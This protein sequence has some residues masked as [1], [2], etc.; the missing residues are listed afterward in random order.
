[1]SELHNDRRGR[2]LA[3]KQF[4][5]AVPFTFCLE[6]HNYR[7]NYFVFV[8]DALYFHDLEAVVQQ[9]EIFGRIASRR[10]FD[11][12]IDETAFLCKKL[13]V[14]VPGHQ[15]SA[16]IRSLTD[17]VNNLAIST[18][19]GEVIHID[20]QGNMQVW[21][22]RGQFDLPCYE[23]NC[24]SPYFQMLLLGQRMKFV[25]MDGNK[26]SIRR[27][28]NIHCAKLNSKIRKG[29]PLEGTIVSKELENLVL[30]LGYEIQASLQIVKCSQK[31]IS[32]QFQVGDVVLI[33]SVQP[34]DAFNMNQVEAYHFFSHHLEIQMMVGLIIRF[35]RKGSKSFITVALGINELIEVECET[36]AHI[37]YGPG[38]YVILKR[39]EEGKY[40]LYKP[41]W[42]RYVS[43][44]YGPKAEVNTIFEGQY[45]YYISF[46]NSETVP[47]D[48]VNEIQPACAYSLVPGNLF[49]CV[50]KSLGPVDSV[51]LP[52]LIGQPVNVGIDFCRT[53]GLTSPWVEYIPMEDSR[54]D[55]D[56]IL[57]MHPAPGTTIHPSHQV[58]YAVPKKEI[59]PFQIFR[60]E[61]VRLSSSTRSISQYL[62]IDSV[63]DDDWKILVLKFFA[64]HAYATRFQL[65]YYLKLHQLEKEQP[66]ERL[67]SRCL[68][69]NILIR[70]DI[71]NE[72]RCSVRA[73]SL[74]PLVAK[75]CHKKVG[76]RILPHSFLYYFGDSATIKTVLSANQAYLYLHTQYRGVSSVR[77]YS[78]FIQNIRPAT[79]EKGLVKIYLC[80]VLQRRAVLFF[81]SIR[82]YT[83][84]RYLNKK[85]LPY[86]EE[87]INK[88][89]RLETFVAERSP[90]DPYEVI[91]Y[92]LCETRNH[93]EL[94]RDALSQDSRIQGIRHIQ[95][96]YITD[97]D[98]NLNRFDPKTS[99]FP[100]IDMDK[101][102]TENAI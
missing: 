88:I 56:C 90:W 102:E 46:A 19:E 12:L 64:Y 43:F 79:V 15:E 94:L 82:D 18:V 16:Y 55:E 98:T 97:I 89:L 99:P 41:F 37:F 45:Q 2:F 28:R 100:Q 74:N 87:Y 3:L 7:H 69:L 57:E 42:K 53:H 101:E 68:A 13:N 95:L 21:T 35:V 61:Q 4:Y 9:N 83:K 22:N 70:Y 93:Q 65:L 1:M 20:T 24:Q 32:K 72:H 17:Y 23:H 77:Y 27:Y 51:I 48:E 26:V 85:R 86:P 62:D 29:E 76:D 33:Q 39:E 49:Y 91:L 58:L 96:R 63:F 8:N 75:K 80:C 50:V 71:Q 10:D 38:H 30:D 34:L 36:T 31:V 44:S 73:Y 78:E 5:L 6:F 14:Y 11:F 54:L 59:S 67:L 92:L 40:S 81:E 60:D 66:L 25:V 84:T 52:D 47:V